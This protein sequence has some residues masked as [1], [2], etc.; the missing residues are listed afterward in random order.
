M[1]KIAV[2]IQRMAIENNVAVFDV[3]QISN[4]GSNYKL[5]QMIPSK[6]SGGLVASADVGLVLYKSDNLL[7]LAIA[8]NKFGDSQIETI[9]EYNFSK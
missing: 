1:T 9:L 4:E 8:K 3:S 7:K 6:G 2:Q 5:G